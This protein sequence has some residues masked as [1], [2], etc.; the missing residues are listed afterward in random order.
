VL[1]GVKFWY[2]ESVADTELLED[3]LVLMEGGQGGH[4]EVK[5]FLALNRELCNVKKIK[6]ST[7]SLHNPGGQGILDG[8]HVYN[9]SEQYLADFH[10][11]LAR[12]LG[13]VSYALQENMNIVV[14]W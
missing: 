12:Y 1:H 7:T 14:W 9:N 3:G 13:K 6:D 10:M 8:S 2:V 4:K 5:G 11:L